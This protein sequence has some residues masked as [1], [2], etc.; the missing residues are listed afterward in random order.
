MMP[1]PS[2]IECLAPGRF[3][4]PATLGESIVVCAGSLPP[5]HAIA[6]RKGTESGRT[7]FPSFARDPRVEARLRTCALSSELDRSSVGVPV[8]FAGESGAGR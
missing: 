2:I 6:G 5:G 8:I 4:L 3:R 7:N 1:N